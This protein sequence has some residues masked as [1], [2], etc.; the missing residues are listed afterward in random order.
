VLS[1]E[2]CADIFTKIFNS[3]ECWKHATKLINHVNP[4]EFWGPKRSFENNDAN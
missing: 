1:C 3:P 4:A 2:Q